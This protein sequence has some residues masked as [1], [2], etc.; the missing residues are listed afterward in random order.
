MD[1][2]KNLKSFVVPET[3]SRPSSL[4][5]DEEFRTNYRW[6]KSSALFVSTSKVSLIFP[7][8]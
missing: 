6:I 8:I 2:L 4:S 3:V 7:D 5:V 1:D